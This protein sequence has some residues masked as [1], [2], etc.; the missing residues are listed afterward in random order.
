MY[1]AVNFHIRGASPLLMHNGHLADPMNPFA[2]AMKAIS[3]K[4]KKTDADYAELAKIE[5]LGGLYT[6]ENG[7]PVI[8]GE[9]LEATIVAGAKTSKKGKVA[10]SAII[11]DG[12][13]PLDYAG[14]KSRDALFDDAN[15]RHVVGVRVGQARVMRTRPK[16]NRW[17][18]R[19]QVNY[20]PDVLDAG[21]VGDFV[22]IA[23]RVCGLGDGRP[24]FGR[25][26]VV[27]AT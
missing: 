13:F 8:P 14:P 9:V 7:Q 11:V 3:A 6:D 1:K 18:L 24:R 12:N 21:E 15:H 26:D 27:E 25:F 5:F 10:K 19:F 2:K 17:S 4:R 22:T 20:L 23:G 16:F